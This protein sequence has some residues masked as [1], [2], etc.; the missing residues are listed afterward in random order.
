MTQSTMQFNN[1]IKSYLDF[2]PTKRQTQK[3]KVLFTLLKQKEE[4]IDDGWVDG[5]TVFSHNMFISQYHARIWELEREGYEIE[6]AIVEG[7]NWKKY[8]I[9]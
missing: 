6:S 7:G 2:D 5:L 1:R 9:L 4:N 3:E 8:R